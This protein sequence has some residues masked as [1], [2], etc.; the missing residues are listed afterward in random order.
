MK[1][2]ECTYHCADCFT[3]AEHDQDVCKACGGVVLKFELI[4][5]YRV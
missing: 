5:T 4:A 3:E 1:R 2:K